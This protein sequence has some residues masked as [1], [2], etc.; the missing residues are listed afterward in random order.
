M[1][2]KFH[3]TVNGQGDVVDTEVLEST[4]REATEMGIEAVKALKFV[5]TV[6]GGKRCRMEFPVYLVFR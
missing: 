3:V 6:C 4:C 5:P 2:S 1:I